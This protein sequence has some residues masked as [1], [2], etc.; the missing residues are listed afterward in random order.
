MSLTL[1]IDSMQPLVCYRLNS[2]VLVYTPLITLL[3]YIHVIEGVLHKNHGG[4]NPPGVWI[5]PCITR[6]EWARPTKL[7]SGF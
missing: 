7:R 6:W 5:S 1:C 4:Y 3:C 2:A